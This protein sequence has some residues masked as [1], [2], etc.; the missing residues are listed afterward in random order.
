MKFFISVII[1]NLRKVIFQDFFPLL[2]AMLKYVMKQVYLHSHSHSYSLLFFMFFFSF[3]AFKSFYEF[4][5]LC[6]FHFL[7]STNVFLILKD[8]T[9]IKNRTK[10]HTHTYHISAATSTCVWMC[11]PGYAAIIVM[12]TINYVS[13]CYKNLNLCHQKL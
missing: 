7:S 1:I 5:R 6:S 11:V 8:F 3:C 13:L 10:V 4:S 2:S 9:Y 12:L